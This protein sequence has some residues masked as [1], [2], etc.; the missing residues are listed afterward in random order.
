MSKKKPEINAKTFVKSY[1]NY[2]LEL[3][4][5]FCDI[6][7]YVDFSNKNNNTFSMEFLKLL[8]AVCSEIDVVAKVIASY[9][10]NNF[11]GSRINEWGYALQ[12]KFPEIKDLKAIFNDDYEIQPWKNWEYVKEEQEIKKGE[13]KGKKRMIIKLNNKCKNP[14]WWTAYNKSKH[15]RTSPYNNSN[16]N[17]NRANLKNVVSAFGALFVLE[18]IF[19]I[20]IFKKENIS[21][22]FASSRLFSLEEYQLKCIAELEEKS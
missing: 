9:I 1:W 17:Y 10:D 15:E 19:R 16:I 4:H 2:Y 18:T 7:R 11:K 5:Q 14:I 12:Q 20:Y 13:N 3:E 8:Q 6:R 21:V 22:N